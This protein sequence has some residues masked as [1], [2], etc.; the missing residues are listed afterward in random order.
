MRKTGWNW[1]VRHLPVAALAAGVLA[2]SSGCARVP[3]LAATI[4]EDLRDSDYPRLRPIENL[5]EPLPAP[6]EEAAKLEASLEARRRALERR[7]RALRPPV[8]DEHDRERMGRGVGEGAATV[9]KT[10]G[11]KDAG[12]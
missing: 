5:V 2:L 11:K 6:A 10:G 1:R 4:R 7:A 12:G 9:P 3:E 8:V